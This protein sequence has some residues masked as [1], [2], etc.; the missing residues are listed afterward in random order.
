MPKIEIDRASLVRTIREQ[1]ALPITE[2]E[3]DAL[4]RALETAQSDEEFLA[5]TLSAVGLIAERTKDLR[6]EDAA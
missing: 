5:N 3:A 1:T 4:A 2:D 6:D